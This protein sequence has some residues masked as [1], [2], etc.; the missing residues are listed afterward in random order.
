MDEGWWI[1]LGVLAFALILNLGMVL[2]ALRYRNSNPKPIFGES[3]G[4]LLNPWKD[5]DQAL[6]EL[7][8]KVDALK[9][10]D[11]GK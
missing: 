8:K 9:R 10:R 6:E 11:D 3:I 7:H 5:E 2:S 4:D 1:V